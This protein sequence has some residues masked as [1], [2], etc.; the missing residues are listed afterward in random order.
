MI[1]EG[2]FSAPVTRFG[3]WLVDTRDRPSAAIHASLIDTLFKSKTIFMAGVMN[4][5]LLSSI[6]AVGLDSRIGYTWMVYEYGVAL[7]R[8]I[9]LAAAYRQRARAVHSASHATTD[10]MLF[11]GLAWSLG[12]GAGGSIAL[13]SGNWIM[14]TLSI[15]TVASTAGGIAFRNFAAPRFAGV[16]LILSSAPVAVAALFTGKAALIAMTVETPLLIAT[17]GVAATKLHRLMVRTMV[18]EQKNLHEATHD[19][20]TGVLNRSALSSS[21]D[22]AES[23][24]SI[25]PMRSMF[26]IDLDGFKAVNDRHGHLQGDKL[27]QEV[28]ALLSRLAQEDTPVYRIGG[29]EFVMMM[30]YREMANTMMKASAIIDALNA[31]VVPLDSG[32]TVTIGSSIGIAVFPFDGQTLESLIA[33]ADRGLYRAKTSGRGQAVYDGVLS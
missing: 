2:R 12:I 14:A 13:L 7:L 33:V 19:Y 31:L 25:Q 32:E 6:V 22:H 11:L 18:N 4:S 16:A 15:F 21:F 9:T 8:V 30:P 24:R 27:L 10:F 5:V 1:S 23:T 26:Y 29:D 28:A 17:M 3:R 20:L